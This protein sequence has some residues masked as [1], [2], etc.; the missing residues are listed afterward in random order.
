MNKFFIGL[1]STAIVMMLSVVS[2]GSNEAEA[3][4]RH[5]QK[6]SHTYKKGKHRKARHKKRRT[7]GGCQTLSSS[8]LQRKASQ[9]NKSISSASKK[10]GVSQNLIK[11]VITIESCFKRRA[12]GSLGEKGLMQLMPN[13]AKRLKVRDG[14]SAW[15][16]VHGG[17]KYLAWLLKRYNGNMQRAIAA[18]NAGEGN[19]DKGRI[20]NRG[21]V[22][23]V[24]HAYRKFSSSKKSVAY[25]PV[26]GVKRLSSSRSAKKSATSMYKV[27][28]GDTV[29]EVM[30]QTGT[31]VD[32]IIKM[33]N[34]QRPYRLKAG[35]Q[36]RVSK[37]KKVAKNQQVNKSVTSKSSARQAKHY[38]V[39]AGDTVYNVMRQTGVSVK[40]IIRLN[41]LSVPYDI[42]T[43]QSLR[44][45]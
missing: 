9:Y 43:G 23:K 33:N 11:A 34:L 2:I 1:L 45:Q 8:T 32:S 25:L 15:Q 10:Y 30:R 14:Y 29:Y 4:S 28:L 26:K 5:A 36:L 7:G 41:R 18:Y 13:T 19:I 38:K 12:R 31:S 21:Y 24:L 42:T 37:A 20:P 3:S 35:Q 6:K 40:K 17:A 39:Q 16:N 44:L 22:N 27:K